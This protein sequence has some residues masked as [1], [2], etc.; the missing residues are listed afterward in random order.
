MILA[1]WH[2]F[3]LNQTKII[4][5]KKKHQVQTSLP[6]L[7]LFPLQLW[8]F[9]SFPILYAHIISSHPLLLFLAVVILLLC[10]YKQHLFCFHFALNFLCSLHSFDRRRPALCLASNWPPSLLLRFSSLY[11]QCDCLCIH[12]SISLVCMYAY[13]TDNPIFYHTFLAAQSF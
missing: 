13:R 2:Y 11:F 5:S 1:F 12:P 9:H 4:L 3:F 8:I 10:S 6:F 7:C